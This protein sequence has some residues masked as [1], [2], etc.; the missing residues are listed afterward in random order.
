[1]A[2]VKLSMVTSS[3]IDGYF[4]KAFMFIEEA[5]ISVND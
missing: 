5:L 2:S 1:M 4:I 3:I